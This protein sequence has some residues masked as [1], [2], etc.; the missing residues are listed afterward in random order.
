MDPNRLSSGEK[1]LGVTAL[2]L[3]ITSFLSMW[4]KIEVTTDLPEGVPD[5]LGGSASTS[6]SLWDGYG[7]LPKL[8]IVIALLLVIVVIAKAAGALDNANLPVP[9]GL[10]Y[11]GGAA[12]TV[13]T[14]LIALL[15]GAEGDNNV[16]GFGTTIEVNRGLLLYL[17]ILLSLAMAVG[18]FLHMQQE[19]SAPK[20]A[21]GPPAGAPPPRPPG[22]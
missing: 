16:E 9:L 5:T 10:L 15:A 18:A 14:M 3:F 19:G 4:G 7:L 6:F 8:G 11:V 12:I 20:G 2:V 1:L 21:A 13:I 17:G 22:T